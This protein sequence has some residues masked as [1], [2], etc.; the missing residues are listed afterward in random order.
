LDG[1]Q[2]RRNQCRLDVDGR[3]APLEA[4]A[5]TIATSQVSAGVFVKERGLWFYELAGIVAR[6]LIWL[7]GRLEL[8]GVENVPRSGPVILAANH[9]SMADPVIV[10]AVL[11][12]ATVFMAKDDLR[13]IPGMPRV[14]EHFGSFTVRRGAVDRDAIRR[15]IEVLEQGRSLG[16]FP[17]GTRSRSGAIGEPHAGVGM[18]ALRTGAPVVPIGISGT[19]EVR[20]TKLLWRRPRIVVRVGKPI[21]SERT[22]GALRGAAHEYAEHVM[23]AI[24]ALLPEKQRGRFAT[25]ADVRG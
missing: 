11:P 6:F 3:V 4:N 7:L 5:A 1:H 2:L 18:L 21:S 8:S 10:A 24:A 17:E 23:E 25:R 20:P 9:L 19:D 16:V 22:S 12:R 14:I 13:E 15:A